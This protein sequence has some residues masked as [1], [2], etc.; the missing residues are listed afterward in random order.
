MPG[1]MRYDILPPPTPT[2]THD[3][4]TEVPKD[5]IRPR[6][7]RPLDWC[8]Y[9]WV[10]MGRYRVCGRTYA[11]RRRHKNDRPSLGPSRSS[12]FSRMCPRSTCLDQRDHG[13]HGALPAGCSSAA[14]V[15]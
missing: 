12:T 1:N 7:T 3:Y 11:R 4:P 5:Y 14:R 15:G 6:P 13:Q 9:L 10:H 8:S 2:Q